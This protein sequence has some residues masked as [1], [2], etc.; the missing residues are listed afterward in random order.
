MTTR[1][2]TKKAYIT[3]KGGDS[4]TVFEEQ[5]EEGDK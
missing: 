5:K 4:I 2:N 3:L 1:P